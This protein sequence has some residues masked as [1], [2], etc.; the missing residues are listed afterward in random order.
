V[1]VHHHGMR[2]TEAFMKLKKEL[3]DKA[4]ISEGTDE[5]VLIVYRTVSTQVEASD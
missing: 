1:Y 4:R 2:D 5:D 3:F